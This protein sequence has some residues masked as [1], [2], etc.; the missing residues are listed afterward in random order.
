MMGENKAHPN[1]SDATVEINSFMKGRRI[2][3]WWRVMVWPQLCFLLVGIERTCG[4][5]ILCESVNWA[6]FVP[7][8]LWFVIHSVYPLN[9]LDAMTPR[10]YYTVLTTSFSNTF[11]QFGWAFRLM[12]F[13]Y[14]KEEATVCCLSVWLTQRVAVKSNGTCTLS[15]KF[16][17]CHTKIKVILI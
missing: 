9:L 1:H 14:G 11:G 15:G 10:K 16:H 3:L 13:G 8:S 17:F 2:R 5:S 4:W 6:L 12:S 7:V